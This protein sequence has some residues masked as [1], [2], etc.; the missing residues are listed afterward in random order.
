M[1]DFVH[2]NKKLI[3]IILALIILPFAFWGVDSYNQSGSSAEVVATVDDAKITQREFDNGLR[4]QQD[5]LRQML[6]A[7]FDPAMLDSPEI[8]RA[9][10]DNLVGQRLLTE[11][12][13][14]IGLVVSD[15][16]MARV[17]QG[18]EAFQDNGKFDKKRYEAAL[19]NQSMSPLMFEARLRGDLLGQQMRDAYLQNGFASSSVADNVIRLYEQ[20]RVVSTSPVSFQPFMAQAQ[21]DEAALQKYYEQNQKEFQVQEQAKVEYVKFSADNLLSKAE[22]SAEDARKYYDEHQS[23]FGAPEERQAAHILVTATA[24]APQAEQDAAKAKAEQ[25]L[26]QVRLNPAKFAE[27]AKQNSQDPGSAANGGDLGFFGRGMMVK[28]F[29]DA[30][31]ALK[32]QGEI[33][34]LV[35]SD[36]GYHIIKLL[37]VKP[38]RLLPFDE[39]RESI[40]DK[41]RRQKATDMF[42]ELAEKFSNTVYEQSDT[43]KPA[44]EL[45]GAKIEQ[46]GWL[47]KGAAAGEPWTAKML[48]AVFADEVIK[49][50]RNTAAIEVAA[51]TLVAA[52]ILEYKPA[53]VQSL[54]EAQATI[55]Q[56]L[57]R[58]QAM[59]MAVKQGEA[60][61]EQLQRGDKPKLDWAAAQTISRAQP[62][63]LDAELARKIF[64]ADT[65]VLPRYVGAK[66]QQDGYM[67]VRVEA[68]KEAG[69]LG[70]EKRTGYVQKLRQLTGEEMFRAY[71][72]A[73]K[74]QAAIKVNL[75]NT[76]SESG[77]GQP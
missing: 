49:D 55:R 32:Q 27:L 30:T 72:A 13:K 54:S 44:A 15:A 43:L 17:I 65:T 74:Q 9:V 63:T 6:G 24:A 37:S 40:I 46:S 71:Q 66:T 45:T 75:A 36:F 59:E 53:S 77:T 14:A 58:Q 34:E 51:N 3:Q 76:A 64:Q 47:V 21:V 33:T 62:G 70:D 18:I 19:A 26:Q 48:Q 67:L 35:K 8:R 50:K 1:F 56:K 4:Q 12:A 29:E 39:A 60:L 11:R 20:Q 22:V 10:I 61:L 73:A 41:L 23:E 31:F 38:A 25:L 52:R 2:G 42:A 5:R 69:N 57:L 68:V 16:Q 7:N 28:P